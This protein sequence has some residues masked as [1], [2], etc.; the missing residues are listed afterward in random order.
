LFL[1]LAAIEAN[2]HGMAVQDIHRLDLEGGPLCREALQELKKLPD[3]QE[4]AK[5]LL[6]SAMSDKLLRPFWLVRRLRA[7]LQRA[8]AA[9]LNA[10]S[11]RGCGCMA[12]A[13][14]RR[15]R[16]N[17]RAEDVGLNQD[18]QVLNAF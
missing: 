16:T 9:C 5:I 3:R 4:K 15:G 2:T 1:F 13:G 17:N 11:Q 12:Y 7:A 6:H 8:Y 14:A 10:G 18:H